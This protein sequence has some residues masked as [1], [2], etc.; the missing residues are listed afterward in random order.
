MCLW[1]MRLEQLG[2]LGFMLDVV[3]IRE[4][5]YRSILDTSIIVNRCVEV[6]CSEDFVVFL[7][8]TSLRI[9]GHL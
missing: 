2:F 8:Q 1:S 3:G 6:M 4:T 5:R 9:S 7:T